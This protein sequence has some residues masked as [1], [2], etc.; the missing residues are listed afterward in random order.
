M[1]VRGRGGCCQGCQLSA[2]QLTK[3][4]VGRG[5]SGRTCWQ[6]SSF[7]CCCDAELMC[8]VGTAVCVS[9]VL[10]GADGSLSV[11]VRVPGELRFK[12]GCVS[13]LLHPPLR[14]AGT[15]V[16]G[17]R[18]AACRASRSL[19]PTSA[20]RALS[21]CLTEL[22]IH[23]PSNT[24]SLAL[25][26]WSRVEIIWPITLVQ[27]LEVVF[28]FLV[29][30]KSVSLS[31]T[32][33]HR[34]CTIELASNHQ[35]FLACSAL[36]QGSTASTESYQL[37][38][39]YQQHSVF[40]CADWLQYNSAPSVCCAVLCQ[41]TLCAVKAAL[42][43]RQAGGPSGVASSVPGPAGSA[44][45]TAASTSRITAQLSSSLGSSLGSA[46]SR[47]TGGRQAHREGEA[48]GTDTAGTISYFGGKCCT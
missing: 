29:S 42:W 46:G 35:P 13:P 20:C 9:A 32:P 38:F 30:R 44:A 15:Q 24:C 8:S 4:H 14:A 48:A 22:S 7:V 25:L 45:Q 40:N 31:G 1:C 11:W 18:P 26:L 23:C 28:V 41:V 3:V 2:L 12:L 39:V 19:Q 34:T 21:A 17:A 37:F 6:G 5:S 10:H 16:R 36:R 27:E 43:W 33:K 47:Q